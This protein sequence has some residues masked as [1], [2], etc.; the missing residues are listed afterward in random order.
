M[1]TRILTY[2]QVMPGY[3]DFLHAFGAQDNPQAQY[4]AGFYQ[5]TMLGDNAQIPK[6]FGRSWRQYQICYN[7]RGVTPKRDPHGDISQ[8]S[9][10]QAAIH[11]QFDVV[12]GTALWTVTKGRQD[13]LERFEQFTK[14]SSGRFFD[15][16]Q[17]CFQTS[18]QTHRMFCHWAAEDWRQYIDWLEDGLESNVS[19]ENHCKNNQT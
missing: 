15:S 18:M 6:M 10:R 3:L 4:F 7:L 5:Q 17:A 8:W 14:S 13:L 1:L 2:H 12:Y 16:L 9:V 11:H 19:S